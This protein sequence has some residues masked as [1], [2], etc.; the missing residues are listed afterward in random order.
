M[1]HKVRLAVLV[2]V[3]AN[4]LASTAFALP[5]A[6]RPA[7]VRAGGA[8]AVWEW[9]V[10]L[11]APAA[12]FTQDPGTGMMMQKA[13]SH[14]DPDGAPLSGTIYSSSTT[15]TGSQMDQNGTR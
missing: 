12:L 7:P 14:M 10:G 6:S 15:E 3:L 5:H 11:F 13:G 1:S 9:L 8:T 4:L 2:L